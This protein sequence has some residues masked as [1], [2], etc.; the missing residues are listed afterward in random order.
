[1][2]QVK[3]ANMT[4]DAPFPVVAYNP[5]GAAIAAGRSRSRI[6]LAVKNGELIARKDGRATLIEA[7]ELRRWIRS[8]PTI[9]S[10]PATQRAARQRNLA[11]A[12]ETA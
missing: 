12:S 4:S 3:Q 2:C 6:F 7:S 10:G 1:M 5:A 11:A 9:D 8:L